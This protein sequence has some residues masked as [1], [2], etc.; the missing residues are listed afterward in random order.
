MP[1]PATSRPT[2]GSTRNGRG[3]AIRCASRARRKITKVTTAIAAAS[4]IVQRKST[5]SGRAK[6]GRCSGLSEMSAVLR[7][8]SDPSP[9]ETSDPIPAASS[10]GIRT[11]GM[12]D[13]PR[14][15]ASIRITAA[16]IG[17]P[18][19]KDTA[20]KVAEVAS[21]R[22]SSGGA[23]GRIAR[24]MRN[25]MPPPSAIRGASGPT[26]SPSPIEAMAAKITP[27]RS[28]GWVGEALRPSAGTCPP[29]P[30]RRAI[31]KA[32]TTPANA[33]TGR[34]HHSGVP[35]SKPRSWGMS[36]NTQRWR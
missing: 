23:S 24:T 2:I 17:D 11:S 32:V 9:I 25:P 6:D 12:R 34:Y 13:P 31:A 1:S 8:V 29:L 26:T 27:G 10:P 7:P 21:S 36:V 22:P 33:S 28:T 15:A 35:W 14:P 19:R 16:M 4:G 20:A 3:V 5:K 30:G 18:N